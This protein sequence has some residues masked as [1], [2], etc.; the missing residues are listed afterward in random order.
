MNKTREKIQIKI[1][2]VS[3]LT[4]AILMSCIGGLFY[5]GVSNTAYAI[6]TDNILDQTT[7]VGELL[8]DNY[9]DGKG[10]VI[11]MET[12]WK[13]ITQISGI[14]N[15]NKDS[16]KELTLTNAAGLRT[17][18]ANDGNKDIV[19]TIGG[20]QW[21]ATYLSHN[22][23]GEP[24]LTLWLAYTTTS[25][26][27]N[28][29][30]A[31][32]KDGDYP[33]S[34]YG[35]SY[36]R[37]KTL[38]NG[39]G[40]ADKYND[41]NLTPVDQDPLSEWA[42]YTME[43]VNGSIASL[44][45]VPENV[46]WQYYLKTT[47]NT[48]AKTDYNN[49]G[50]A[51]GGISNKI[52]YLGK[53]GYDGWKNDKIWIPALSEVG[54]STTT[55]DGLWQTSINQRANK[56]DGTWT[57]SAYSATFT[58]AY[59]IESS[60]KGTSYS[61]VTTARG[62]RPAFHLNLLS[63]ASQGEQPPN[64]VKVEYT[65]QKLNMDNVSEK[66][67]EWY[68]SDKM[69]IEY[70]SAN[71]YDMIDSGTYSV[72]ATLKNKDS[73]FE[74]TP[75][76]SDPNHLESDTVRWFKFTITKTKIGV[77]VGL[78]TNELPVVTLTNSDDVYTGDTGDRAPTLGFS[79]TGGNISGSTTTL[80][81]AVGSYTATAIIVND[82]NY[83]LDKTYSTTFKIN[84][85]D[86]PK[87]TISGQASKEYN[88]SDI[89]FTLT[90]GDNDKI[91][92]E[93]PEGMTRNG[94]TLTAKKAGKYKVVATLA[95]NGDATQ[96]PDKSIGKVELEYE[97]TK[98]PLSITITCSETDFTWTVGDTPTITISCDQCAGDETDLYIYYIDSKNP[99][100]KHDGINNDKTISA[101][102]T[103]TITMPGDIAQGSYTIG[104][105]LYGSNKDNDN[106]SLEAPK[107][108]M[109]TVNGEEVT[110][111][112]VTWLYNNNNVITDTSN[113]ELTYTGT[114][115]QFSV[116]TDKLKENG[117]KV[118]TTK[119]T[120]GYSGNVSVTNAGTAYS[121]TV[122]VTNY[123][124]SYETY[125]ATFTLN[126]KINKAKYDLSGLS[127]PTSNETEYT[128][129][130]QSMT[131]SGT[132]P[133][134][135]TVTYSGNNKVPANTDDNPTYTTTVTFKVSDT[136]N[137]YLPAKGVRD[138]Y[139]YTEGED[140]SFDFTWKIT[141][142]TLD[143]KGN[144][145]D[146]NNS[147][148][149]E[150]YVLPTLKSIGGLDVDSMVEY[151]Y[152]DKDNNIITTLPSNVTEETTY[153]AKVT[154]KSQY[155][156]NYQIKEGTDTYE[157]TIGQDKYVVVLT[158]KY[159]GNNIDGAE[160][161]YMGSAI[162]PTVEITKTDGG[163][164]PANIT[165]TYYK[166]NDTQGTTTAPTAVGRYTV[167]ATL[168]Y[169]GDLNYIDDDSAEFD[170][171]II[172][173]D[174][175]VSGLKWTYTHTDKEG[176]VVSAVYDIENK[177]WL[178]SDGNEI[179]VMTYD[180]TAHT[181]TLEGKDDISGLTIEVSNYENTNADSYTAVVAFTYDTDSYNAPKF[182]TSLAWS[183]AKAKIDTSAI[184][185]GYTVGVSTDEIAYTENLQYTR[186]E[187]GEVKY[188][189]KLINVPDELK[190]YIDYMGTRSSNGVGSFNTTY[191]VKSDFDANNYETLVM[192]SGLQNRLNWEVEAK[193]LEKPVYDNSWTTFN[194]EVHDFAQMFGITDA[195]WKLYI[196]MIITKDGEE[197]LG[198]SGEDYDHL[199]D[200]EFKAINAG[201]YLVKFEIIEPSSDDGV[202]DVLW[203]DRPEPNGYTIQVEKY[204]IDVEKW[205]GS[206]ENATVDLETWVK[207]F[208]TY[209]ITDSKGNVV[210]SNNMQLGEIYT[211]ELCT[212]TGYEN[213]IEITG[214][215]TLSVSLGT[216][217]PTTKANPGSL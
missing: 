78:D 40:Y 197:Y 15:P 178:N 199:T 41:E 97:I 34:M 64:D 166:D 7:N 177:K 79:Y 205:Q 167:K 63:V 38:N 46:D 216:A 186:V 143:L 201:E 210:N 179:G 91:K 58:G 206:N 217:L 17:L 165:L 114:A 112:G 191:Y 26:K 174:F 20:K 19:I 95:D 93:L 28:L 16:L 42:I 62:V 214:K 11:N 195:D 180:K 66:E 89:T 110:L 141:P 111:E 122:Y 30:T 48:A 71:T 136:D 133:Q 185:W 21:T 35:T 155:A 53:P 45:D 31:Q 107:T 176:N 61:Y 194:G 203:L 128:G 29:S 44:I 169:G 39:G 4:L 55:D 106:Y 147:S 32:T 181:L 189:I 75:N 77:T 188:T 154:L 198:L 98:K 135:L 76:K 120:N 144:W 196:K 100:V 69:T 121:V 187:G 103:R 83:E 139:D 123:D 127:W 102:G 33:N 184:V 145:K 3:I 2:V 208:I 14:Q 113:V 117:T 67:K 81:T 190:D 171:E 60:G 156:S 9:D 212:K 109:F 5:C 202:V 211:K 115:Y 96:W 157:F 27:F 47:E 129:Q 170:F 140:F 168:N 153:T 142:K 161:A 36:I 49:D 80:P 8:R 99:N 70:P 18:N 215:K 104:V 12:F 193:K 87:P 175:D 37:A 73:K 213:D 164:V 162:T 118:D 182:P 207:P 119:G 131:L 149:S 172:K 183:I 6:N 88:G 54:Y 84:K 82:C 92:F 148:E 56:A 1:A 52:S 132:F 192:P 86:V 24:I 204:A 108:A 25:E 59:K 10:R 105:E 173:A 90:G 134:G 51:A 126:Y 125:N 94:N 163:I 116:D 200:K 68:D 152:Y 43:E 138:T 85:L 146:D 23:D 13:L 50:L 151:T 65:G 160:I 124:S 74:G 22:K 137:Y 72:K 158:F 130:A 150:V 159:N 101:D 57:R 209:K